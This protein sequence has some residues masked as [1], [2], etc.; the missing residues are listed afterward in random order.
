F[1]EQ[2]VPLGGKLKKARQ[3]Y[4]QE[5]KQL[6]IGTTAQQTSIKN[7][8]RMAFFEALGTQQQV[9]INSQLVTIA[10]QAVSTTSELFNVGQA[11]KPDFL[12][13]QI[14]LEEV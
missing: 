1:F 4:D 11:D 5:A 2:T 14:E 6:E 12:Q 9:E 7:T 3:I 13:A 8:V 10:Q